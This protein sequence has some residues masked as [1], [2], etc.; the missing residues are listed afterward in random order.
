[1]A[2]GK[3]EGLGTRPQSSD[4]ELSTALPHRFPFTGNYLTLPNQDSNMLLSTSQ[5]DL[6]Y[7]T[8]GLE[9]SAL[10]FLIPVNTSTFTGGEKRF[11]LSGKE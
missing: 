10:T 6:I 4:I 11:F 1:M 2:L 5:K 7:S 8:H 3:N 9:K